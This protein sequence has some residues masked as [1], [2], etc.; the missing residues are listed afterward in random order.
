MMRGEATEGRDCMGATPRGSGAITAR[1]FNFLTSSSSNS[2]SGSFSHPSL[3][4]SSSI[5]G[6][7]ACLDSFM[8]IAM[9]QTEEYVHGQ[10]KAKYG[11][12]FIRGNNGRFVLSWQG[13]EEGEGGRGCGVFDLSS[14]CASRP[15]FCKV[16]LVAAFRSLSLKMRLRGGSSP[17]GQSGPYVVVK[18]SFNMPVA[19]NQVVL[20]LITPSLFLPPFLLSH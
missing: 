3:P 14:C 18:L 17:K 1:P 2:S 8:N 6:V 4:L 9:E 16:R 10:L 7:L 15:F 12:C 19:S 11:D 13:G 20:P 5:T